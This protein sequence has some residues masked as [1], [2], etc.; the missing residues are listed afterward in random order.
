M[1]KMA[2]INPMFQW[3]DIKV[4]RAGTRKSRFAM[5]IAEQHSNTFGIGHGG[6]VF[7][8]ADLAFG[9]TCNARGEMA[10]TANAS[11]DYLRPVPLGETLIADVT[12][13]EIGS[14]NA[15]YDVR[16]CL[17]SN[18]EQAVGLVRGRMRIIGGPPV[19]Q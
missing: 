19:E 10:V 3:L 17:K 15:F 4:V 11:I 14:R 6:I 5:V 9:F 8:F 12:E 18:E 1:E 2:A 13:T 16:L 7:A